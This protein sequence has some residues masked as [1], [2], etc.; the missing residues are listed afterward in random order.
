MVQ[1]EP[2]VKKIVLISCVSRKLA[3]PASAQDLS[4]SPR[5]RLNLQHARNLQPDVIYIL[6]AKNGL[7]DFFAR[8]EPPS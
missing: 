4:V 8:A 1:E 2:I 3:H 5:F 6:W 7:L